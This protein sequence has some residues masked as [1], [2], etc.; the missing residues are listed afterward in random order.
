MPTTHEW[1]LSLQREIA[2]STVVEVNYIGRRAYH[3]FGA[4][5]ANQAEIFRNGFVDAFNV[6]KN[7][8]DSPLINSLTSA[9]SRRGANETGAQMGRRLFP[10][11]L[12][13][14]SGGAVAASLASRIQNGKSVVALSGP[15]TYFF[16]PYP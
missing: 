1:G 5:N 15:N 13:L 6:V 9:D 16:Y 4:Y 3:L 2:K 10:S 7:G 12:T 14:D 8:G 11:P